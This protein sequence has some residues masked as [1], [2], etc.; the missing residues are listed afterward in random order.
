MGEKTIAYKLKEMSASADKVRAKEDAGEELEAGLMAEIEEA[1]DTVDLLAESAV[2]RLDKLATEKEEAKALVSARPKMAFEIFTGDV[3]QYPT[4]LSNQEQLY[5]MFYDANAPDK[6]ALQLLFQLSKILSPDLA[7]SVLSYSG[8]ENSAQKAADWLSLKFDSPQLMVPVIFQELKDISPVRIKG[9]VPRVAERVLR[10]IESLS[11]ITKNDNSV[12]P[13]NVVQAVFRALYLSREEKKAVLHYL[14]RPATATITVIHLYIENRFKEYELMSSTLGPVNRYKEPKNSR[15]NNANILSGAAATA[16]VGADGTGGQG[17][18]GRRG[19]K[20]SQRKWP[21]AGCSGR[22][23]TVIRRPPA[24][25]KHK[26]D[27]C[28]A[29]SRP[30][31]DHHITFCPWISSASKSDLLTTMPS[32]CLGCF[33][34]KTGTHKCPGYLS[35]GQS[36][37]KYFCTTCK[38]NKKLCKA[39]S[40]YTP[41]AIPATFS[42]HVSGR[43]LHEEKG[44]AALWTQN[45]VNRGSKGSP[46]Y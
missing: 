35:D 17:G 1:L 3:S 4:F 29:K 8:S 30:S 24:K 45:C 12:L 16:G 33:K 27:F 39:P 38:T 46:A 20:Y 42:G 19:R 26:C 23:N 18:D 22:D 13:S 31:T 43:A 2:I 25:G 14:S 7:K 37:R 6:G 28:V 34:L 11:A 9:E 44:Q 10:K 36:L 41:S 32:L 5:D 21:D 15:L 40:M